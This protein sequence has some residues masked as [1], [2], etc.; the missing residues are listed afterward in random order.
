MLSRRQAT[1]LERKK[2]IANA[3]ESECGMMGN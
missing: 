2:E 3:D 1:I